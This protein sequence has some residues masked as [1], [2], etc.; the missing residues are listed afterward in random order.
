V[1]K[2]LQEIGAAYVPPSIDN[3]PMLAG[4]DAE[5]FDIVVRMDGLG[6]FADELKTA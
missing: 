4:E 3:P 2:A 5:L 1:S 6:T